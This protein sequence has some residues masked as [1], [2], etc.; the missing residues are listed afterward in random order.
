MC[1]RPLIGQLNV[2]QLT[3]GFLEV[4]RHIEVNAVHL[5]VVVRSI[6]AGV[7]AVVGVV[8]LQIDL[9]FKFACDGFGGYLIASLLV[10]DDKRPV[11]GEGFG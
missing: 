8:D 10:L 1:P 3:V 6:R 11:I 2:C 5:I 9:G 7:G 4:I